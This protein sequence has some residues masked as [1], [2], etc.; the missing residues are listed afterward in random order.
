VIEPGQ[1]GVI[2]TKY[3][4]VKI[5][6]PGIHT[7]APWKDMIVYDVKETETYET[8]EVL[9]KTGLSIKIDLSIIHHPISDKIGDFHKNIGENYLEEIIKP[10]VRSVT[11]EV[12][13][14]YFAEEIYNTIRT[15]VEFEIY[16]K[17]SEILISKNINIPAIY[18]RDV[19]LP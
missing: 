16:L 13:V 7:I 8:M 18:I 15:E 1:K 3:G 2:E 4:E 5:F 12:I 10:T 6:N 11:R 9:D 19:T 17:T 14:N